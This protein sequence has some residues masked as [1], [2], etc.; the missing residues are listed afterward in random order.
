MQITENKYHQT[1]KQEYKDLVDTLV[2]SN[3]EVFHAYT[4]HRLLSLGLLID[5]TFSYVRPESP[6]QYVSIQLS[7]KEHG[8]VLF[9]ID[10][11]SNY[12]RIADDESREVLKVFLKD[13]NTGLNAPKKKGLF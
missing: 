6:E 10:V 11:K 7:L 12:G 2:N 13:F 4:I 5:F 3:R 8:M 9:V 1:I